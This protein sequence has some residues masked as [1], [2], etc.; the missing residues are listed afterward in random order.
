MAEHIEFRPT[1][2]QKFLVGYEET[3]TGH[4]E[5]EAE[6]IEQAQD[7]VR[8]LIESDKLDPTKDDEDHDVT[9]YLEV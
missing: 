7:M 5:V 3:F 9:V 4:K 8:E 6:S 1:K 2:K